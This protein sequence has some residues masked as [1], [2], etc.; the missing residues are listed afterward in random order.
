MKKIISI[1]LA[2]SMIFSITTGIFLYKPKEAKAFWGIGDISIDPVQFVKEQILDNLVKPVARHMSIRL[3]QEIARWA[4]GGF[5]DENKPF[6]MTSW[7]QEVAEALNIAS[8]IYIQELNLTPLCTPIRI[9]IGTALGLNMP[10]NVPYT[11]YAA[12]TLQDIVDNIEEFYKNPS[13]AV[14]GWDTWTALTQSNNN[15]LGSAL[16]AFQEKSQVEKQ[17]I[18]EKGREIQVGQGIKNETICTETQQEACAKI[19]IDKYVATING[20]PNPVF[21]ACIKSC[22][23]ADLGICLQKQT[24]KLGSEIKASVDKAIG[25]DIDWLIT[26][27]EITEM[28]GLVFSG[29]FTKLTHGIN[30]ML[31]KATSSTSTI[32]ANQAK[33]GYYKDYK[34]TQTPE[35]ITNLKTDILTNILNSIKQVSATGYD[36]NEDNQLKGEVYQEITADI[37][38]EESQHLYAT[39]EGVDLKP[40]FEALDSPQAVKNGIAIYGQT[41]ND[42]P[43][44]RYPDQCTKI[45]NKKCSDI[46]TGLPFELNVANINAECTTGCHETINNYRLQGISDTEAI[47]KAVADGKCSSYSIGNACLQGGYLIDKTKNYCNECVKKY[48]ESCS[49]KETPEETAQCLETYCGNYKEISSSIKDSQDFYN[50]CALNETKYSCEVCL[51]EY[52]MPADY[53]EQIYDYINRAFIKYPALVYS[54]IWWGRRI[55]F[56][57]DG[58]DCTKPTLWD[59]FSSRLIGI[60]GWEQNYSSIISFL[61]GKLPI[62]T[63]LTCRIMPDFKFPDQGGK[64]CK[65]FCNVTDEEL[66][67]I[68]DNEPNDLD[69]TGP[70]N[71]QS[72]GGIWGADGYHP[73]SQWLDYLIRQKSKCCGAL[74]GHE[75]EKYKKCRGIE[76]DV[77]E[78]VAICSY[79][80]PVSEEPWCYCGEGERPM[81]W[82]K[83]KPYEEYQETPDKITYCANFSFESPEK[84]DVRIYTDATPGGGV[85]Y[86][87]KNGCTDPDKASIPNDDQVASGPGGEICSF[88]TPR[89]DGTQEYFC[90]LSGEK[91]ELQAGV[92]NNDKEDNRGTSMHVCAPCNSGDADYPYYGTDLNQCENKVQ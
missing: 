92:Y 9:S 68:T 76:D 69:C 66:K 11:K 48:E 32:S 62:P 14:Y 27:D 54:D 30:G 87:A 75:P 35:D 79:A 61:R 25:S 88:E 22:E 43:F 55:I 90:D 58:K 4:Q 65:D 41:W 7:K 46:R 91:G 60:F 33:Y 64:G 42:I 72:W 53:C 73:G 16:M 1:I 80:K 20:L 2:A 15:F 13:I 21:V 17:E 51:K 40:D 36:C 59:Y 18:T 89:S 31:T 47:N 34:K 44:K 84:K 70:K 57:N 67:N 10:G 56:A 63:G 3:Q 49:L 38:N 83:T 5:S 37:L 78:D 24:R 71:T 86:I 29:L 28:L 45:A 39:I 26:A 8:G 82:G 6:A 52:F 81:G 50:R 23:K 19:C 12:C 74:L 85:V 77:F